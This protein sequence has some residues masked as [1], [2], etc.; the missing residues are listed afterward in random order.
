MLGVRGPAPSLA[1]P[2]ASSDGRGGAAGPPPRVSIAT[3]HSSAAA[4]ACCARARSRCQSSPVN[5]RGAAASAVAGCRLCCCCAV[6][7]ASAL[8]YPDPSLSASLWGVNVAK[9]TPKPCMD[10]G[11]RQPAS[12]HE[13]RPRAVRAA[14]S[15]GAAARRSSAHMSSSERVSDLGAWRTCTATAA[16]VR[17]SAP[18]RRPRSSATSRSSAA[19]RLPPSAGAPPAAS[20]PL[21]GAPAAPAPGASGAASAGAWRASPLGCWAR[22]CAG[23]ASS[24]AGMSMATAPPE[25]PFVRA[26][27]S[28]SCDGRASVGEAAWYQQ[29]SS[30]IK[31]YGFAGRWV[32]SPTCRALIYIEAAAH[33]E[34]CMRGTPDTGDA[35]AAGCRRQRARRS[36]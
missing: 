14:L 15:F 24:R 13:R 27:A 32:C 12:A 34:P 9:R 16:A 1:G 22:R 4:R 26:A 8:P 11:S 29:P 20:A 18:A 5:L 30:S 25:C 35:S 3:C 19:A 17:L 2:G 28:C 23:G 10:R 33:T 21:A 36:P 6:I 31:E 7:T